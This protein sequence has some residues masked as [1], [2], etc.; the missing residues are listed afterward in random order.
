MRDAAEVERK[1]LEPSTPS[2]QSQC[3]SSEGAEKTGAYDDAS[4]DR[5][6]NTSGPAP[7]GAVP[8]VIEGA[9]DAHLR[10]LV[11]LWPKLSET[12]RA[13]LL[14]VAEASAGPKVKG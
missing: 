7:A 1:G 2:L 14:A 8:G 9:E 6:E 5:R 11:E 13:A 4:A 12:H 10:R 3:Y